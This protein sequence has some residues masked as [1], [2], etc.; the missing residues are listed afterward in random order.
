MFLTALGTM[1]LTHILRCAHSEIVLEGTE[2]NLSPLPSLRALSSQRWMHPGYSLEGHGG[3]P[4]SCHSPA[5]QC[6]HI[7]GYMSIS[8]TQE[9]T[10]LPAEAL[11][12]LTGASSYKRLHVAPTIARYNVTPWDQDKRER[13]LKGARKG[14]W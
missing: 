2:N 9:A 8:K 14:D 6:R 1:Y 4:S 12:S 13:S 11:F 5:E 7:L 10:N 3:H